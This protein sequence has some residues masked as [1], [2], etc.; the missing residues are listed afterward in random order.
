MSLHPRVVW[1]GN[2]SS[3]REQG[4][5]HLLMRELSVVFCGVLWCQLMID[6]LIF[7]FV[8][9]PNHVSFQDTKKSIAT[10]KRFIRQIIL[11]PL[12]RLTK[13]ICCRRNFPPGVFPNHQ[14]KRNQHQLRA[15]YWKTHLLS[16]A[17]FSASFTG[18]TRMKRSANFPTNQS[19][20]NRSWQNIQVCSR[21]TN[22]HH[23]HSMWSGLSVSTWLNQHKV[24][25][26]FKGAEKWEKKRLGVKVSKTCVFHDFFGKS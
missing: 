16:P 3:L 4:E 20:L 1:R 6:W 5:F 2:S 18:T 26:V 12:W 21:D 11:P 25:L 10:V 23:T 24:G 19:T 9:C 22:T 17:W 13:K 14:T 15:F 7:I 8:S